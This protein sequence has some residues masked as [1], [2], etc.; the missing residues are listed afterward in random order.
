MFSSKYEDR[1]LL[2]SKSL[3]GQKRK[4]RK[5]NEI[6]KLKERATDAI[7]DNNTLF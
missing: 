3:S 1:D 7:D 2:D 5:P 4:A 6:L